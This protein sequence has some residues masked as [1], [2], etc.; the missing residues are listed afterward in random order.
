MPPKN[1]HMTKNW[2]LEIDGIE[3][4]RFTSCDIPEEIMDDVVVP[5]SATLYNQRVPGDPPQVDVRVEGP[6]FVDDIVKELWDRTIDFV[7][8]GQTLIDEMY[9]TGTLFQLDRDKKT[10][11]KK[12]DF[13]EMYCGGRIHGKFDATGNEVRMEGFILRPRSID[14]QKM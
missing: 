2:I 7:N 5:E 11:L 4:V 14:P 13:D 9:F 10:K 1:F 3:R 12:W 8:G 6:S